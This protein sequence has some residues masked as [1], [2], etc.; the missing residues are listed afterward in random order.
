MRIRVE[1][2]WMLNG[3]TLSQRIWVTGN[4]LLS[5]FHISSMLRPQIVIVTLHRLSIVLYIVD[6]QEDGESSWC[7]PTPPRRLVSLVLSLHWSGF[8][9]TEASACTPTGHPIFMVCKYVLLC[10]ARSI[11]SWFPIPHSFHFP[12]FIPHS[13]LNSYN[14]L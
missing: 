9:S 3:I 10:P 1:S 13:I 12:F 4:R 11:G 2:L 6:G 5:V 14:S 7:F 8:C